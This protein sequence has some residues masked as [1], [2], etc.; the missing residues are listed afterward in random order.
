[1]HGQAAWG[2]GSNCDRS[3]RAA[4]AAVPFDPGTS[5]LMIF[6]L[7]WA[8]TDNDASRGNSARPYRHRKLAS[9]LVDLAH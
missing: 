9:V 1:M 5:K 7:F 8:R 6:L 2:F 4:S 3:A